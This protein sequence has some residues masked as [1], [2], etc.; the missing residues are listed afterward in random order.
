MPSLIEKRGAKRW[1]GRAQVNGKIREKLFVDDS[2]RSRREAIAWEEK[3]KADRLMANRFEEMFG[4]P[5]SLGLGIEIVP[6]EPIE[7]LPGLLRQTKKRALRRGMD[8][9]L[10]LSHIR[11]L[12][13]KSDGRCSMTGIRFASTPNVSRRPFYP[14]I[15][16]IDSSRGY[17]RP[18]V[19]LVCIAVNMALF[20]WGTS[21]FDYVAARR[22]ERLASE[23]EGR[24]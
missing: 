17:L 11:R 23:R 4:K 3:V 12:W 21:V 7:C 1:K 24:V 2:D 9:D 18:N 10:T 20:S 8:F 6:V 13:A 5:T 19:R 14:S 15:D 22:L 16:R